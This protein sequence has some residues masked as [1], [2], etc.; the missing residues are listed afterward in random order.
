MTLD[1]QAYQDEI[2]ICE[3]LIRQKKELFNDQVPAQVI[4]PLQDRIAY[5]RGRLDSPAGYEPEP[6]IEIPQTMTE[7]RAKLADLEEGVRPLVELISM[8]EH[9]IGEEVVILDA[10]RAPVPAD[11]YMVTKAKKTY[12]DNLVV[13]ESEREPGMV[14]LVMLPLDAQRKEIHDAA[15]RLFTHLQNQRLTFHLFCYPP[16][17]VS[18]E[19]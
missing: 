13:I 1:P 11:A 18:D 15:K 12:G 6:E 10:R 4:A 7:A 5:L 3:E 17:E 19:L 8:P 2:L 16:T 9:I 14:E